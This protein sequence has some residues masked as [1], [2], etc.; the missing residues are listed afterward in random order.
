[1]KKISTIIVFLLIA[2]Y[3]CK[4]DD[5]NLWHEIRESRS[6]DQAQKYLIDYPNTMH[7]SEIIDSLRVFWRDDP[8][9]WGGD[10]ITFEINL[11]TNGEITVEE[12]PSSFDM[13]YEQVFEFIV[14]PNHNPEYSQTTPLGMDGFEN[15]FRYVGL[16]V[17]SSEMG[18]NE[19][20]YKNILSTIYSVIGKIRNDWSNVIFED[21]YSRLPLD[22]KE[23]I[24]AVCP[25]NICLEK[26]KP[27]PNEKPPHGTPIII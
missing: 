24:D 25:I 19:A 11:T 4:V 17:V 10:P 14:N 3:G 21:E 12:V 5:N 23:V 22:E 18:Y 27:G 13:L 6:V 7:F 26:Y 1:M 2:S 20:E 9:I 8:R 15:L 16:L